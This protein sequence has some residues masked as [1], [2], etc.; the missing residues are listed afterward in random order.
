MV[1]GYSL[2]WALACNGQTAARV[3]SVAAQQQGN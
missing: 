2:G 1:H 3:E